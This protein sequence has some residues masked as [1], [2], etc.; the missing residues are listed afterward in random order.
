MEHRM[1]GDE[2]AHGTTL[3]HMQQSWRS[4]ILTFVP[5]NEAAPGLEDAAVGVGAVALAPAEQ[6]HL[7]QLHHGVLQHTRLIRMINQVLER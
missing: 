1:G 4:Q 2:L 7:E 5:L 6:H 3:P